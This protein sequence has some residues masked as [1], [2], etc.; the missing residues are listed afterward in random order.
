M[1]EFGFGMEE[2][3]IL[4][5]AQ[6]NSAM[7][8]FVAGEGTN[9]NISNSKKVLLGPSPVFLRGRSVSVSIGCGNNFF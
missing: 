9:L 5:E 2:A 1:T 3:E 6:T 8:V 7:S 4:A